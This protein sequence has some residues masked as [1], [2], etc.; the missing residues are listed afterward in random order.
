M[1]NTIK[2]ADNF[3]GLP[4]PWHLSAVKPPGEIFLTYTW[5]RCAELYNNAREKVIAL[6]ESVEA[7]VKTPFTMYFSNK[8]G[9]ITH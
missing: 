2:L 1:V 7:K 6:S 8:I 3:A 9:T 4:R 5:N